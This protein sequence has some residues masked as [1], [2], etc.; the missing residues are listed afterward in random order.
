M[1]QPEYRLIPGI[2][3]PIVV[4]ATVIAIDQVTKAIASDALGRSAG[5]HRFEV[6]GSLLA[7]EYV[8]NTGAAFG[9]GEDHVR[10][11]ELG[12]MGEED[13]VALR[14]IGDE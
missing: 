3:L 11:G 14:V 8:E 12:D 13:A 1:P 7:F 6:L 2:V 9:S 10:G 4:A 5:S